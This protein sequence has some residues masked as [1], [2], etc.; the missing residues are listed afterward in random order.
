MYQ[1]VAVLAGNGKNG[2]TQNQ[3]VQR[4]LLTTLVL[5]I[6]VAA[7]KIIIGLLTGAL[8]ITADGFHS[9]IDGT[10]N[11]V[12][13]IAV[14]IA[15]LPPDDDHP[16]GHSRFETL[17]ALVIGSLLLLTAWEIIQGVLER[18]S[19][20]DTPVLT[21]LAFGVMLSTL[22][23]NILVSRYQIRAGHRLNSQI[24]LADAQNTRA[25]VLVT[26]SVLV[27]MAL[28][29]IT[30]WSG[31]DVVAALLVTL[32]IGRAAIKILQQTGR[33]LV[34]TA[35][36]SSAQLTPYV[37]AIPAV[38]RVLRVRSRGTEDAA[39][40]D[41][42]VQVAP[43]MTAEQT[44]AV[45]DAIR[46]NLDENL[47]GVREVEVHFAPEH[48]IVPDYAQLA[49]AR[50]AA[51]S[52]TTHEVCVSDVPAGKVLE[53]H[54]EVPSGQ[55]LAAAHQ[56]VSQLEQAVKQHLPDVVEV[57]THIEPALPARSEDN[58]DLPVQGA[59]KMRQEV[60]DL[61][62]QHFLELEWHQL[63]IHPLHAGFAVSMHLTLA[64]QMTVEAAHQVAE[65][66]EMLLRMNLPLIERVTIHTEPPE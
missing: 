25:D 58:E 3:Q 7:A 27:S 22:M 63:H 51:L 56:Q 44:A 41:V 26:I 4:V 40:I 57:V 55:T 45:G 52:L 35:P 5:N 48:S 11:V 59:Q 30:G 50:A 64:P 29:V 14:R 34:D 47:S 20:G 17:A 32:L 46:A 53:M 9:M 18:L 66:A 62:H 60:A 28:T 10:G 13:L 24:L 8:A 12:G 61:L 2:V 23:V 33:V 1:P 54:V 6:I 38:D 31:V 39:H 49:Q 37:Q 43:N 21:P 15:D 36:Y 42:D 65:H 16:Y 19:S